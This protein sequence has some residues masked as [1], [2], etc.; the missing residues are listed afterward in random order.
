MW[1]FIPRSTLPQLR[2]RALTEPEQ[3]QVAEAA[4]F[5]LERVQLFA[6]FGIDDVLEAKL[7]ISDILGDEAAA[8]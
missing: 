4:H 8:V 6:G 7:V 2:A 5:V 1:V 3:P